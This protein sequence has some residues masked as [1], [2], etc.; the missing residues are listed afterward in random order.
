M[1]SS[2]VGK[3]MLATLDE[4]HVRS[5]L[6]HA[7][8]PRKTSRTITDPDDMLRELEDVAQQGYALDDEEDVD[9]VFCVASVVA[10]LHRALRRCDQ[11]HGPAARP[12]RLAPARARR[13]HARARAPRLRA[14]RRAGRG[15]R[16]VRRALVVERPEQIALVPRDDLAPGPDEVV[17]AP[18]ACGLCGTDLELLHGLVDP[19]FATYPLTLGHEWSGVVAAGRCA[20]RADRAGR[21]RRRRVHRAVRRTA[22]AA[23]PVRRTPAR[24]TTSSASP[25]RAARATRSSCLARLVHRLDPAVSLVDAALTE[26]TAVVLRGFEKATPLPASACS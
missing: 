15:G 10:R 25:A 16:P 6:R 1:H 8:M 7:G 9:G 2:A 18:A 20:R 24:P 12:A 14:A 26:P 19:A 17:I 13:G 3:S 5:L 22:R 11:R 21:S 23:G 4:E